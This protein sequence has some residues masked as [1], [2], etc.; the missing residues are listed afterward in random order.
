MYLSIKLTLYN[1]PFIDSGAR[2]MQYDYI[3]WWK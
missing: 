1:M 3:G 2:F